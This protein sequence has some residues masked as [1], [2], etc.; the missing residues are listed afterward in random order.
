MTSTFRLTGKHVLAIIVGFFMVVII[1]N[2]IFI[3]LAVKSFPG[4]QE[5][6]SYLQG[7]AYNERIAE[8]EAQTLLGWTAEISKASLAADIAEIELQFAS[9]S[10][11]PVTG[12]EVTGTLV[13]PADDGEDHALV[14][15]PSGPGRYRAIV[16]GVAPGAWRLDAIALSG[17]GE[18]F[19]L[20]KRMTL[21]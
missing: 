9:S 16:E 15:E 20:E 18:K 10:S 19:A 11:T 7:L 6:K 14:F 2:T 13:R 4:E 21:E 1:A 5:K 17:D 3:T 12:L 8:R